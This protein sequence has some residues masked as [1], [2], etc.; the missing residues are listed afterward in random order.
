M[1]RLAK[2]KKGGFTL[3]EVLMTISLIMIVML[4]LSQFVKNAQETSLK[5]KRKQEGGSIGQS[6]LEQIQ[7][8][9]ILRSED[10]EIYMLIKNGNDNEKIYFNKDNKEYDFNNSAS[11]DK[12]RIKPEV[13]K[14]DKYTYDYSTTNTTDNREKIKIYNEDDGNVNMDIFKKYNSVITFL[15]NGR[16]CFN[17]EDVFNKSYI[18]GKEL[19]INLYKDIN[20]KYVYSFYDDISCIRK[21]IEINKSNSDLNNTCKILLY[22]SETGVK[23]SDG[24]AMEDVFK[25]PFNG[26]VNISIKNDIDKRVYF[27]VVKGK[28]VKGNINVESKKENLDSQNNFSINKYDYSQTTSTKKLGDLYEIKIKVSY[29]KNEED[30]EILFNSKTTKNLIL[31]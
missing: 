7:N 25:E 20:G 31:D 6:V 12:F 9:D 23:L 13:E 1:S 21:D 30:K 8:A 28:N 14:V 16:I 19:M 29:I 10:G 15:N 2:K 17:N 18:K 27:D 4:P 24:N 3:I 22:F 5:A 11:N 26:D